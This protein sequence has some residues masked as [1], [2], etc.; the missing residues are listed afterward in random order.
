MLPVRSAANPILSRQDIP[1]VPPELVDVSSVF[2]PGAV[3]R[4]GRCM[5]MLRVQTRGRETFFL[6]AESDDGVRFEVERRVVHIRGMDRVNG[7]VYHCYDARITRLE[8]AYYAMFAMDTDFGCRLGLAR[9]EDF[10]TF[11]FVG[12][13]GGDDT[14]NGVLFPER[15]D[16]C[17]LRLERPNKLR[18]ESGVTSGDEI[19]LST[20]EDLIDWRPAGSVMRG[21]LHYWD[22]LIGPGPPPVKTHEGWLLIYHGIATHGSAGIYQAGVALLDLRNPSNLVARGRNNVLEPRDMYEMTGQVPNVVFPTGLIIERYDAE[23][24]A[25]P[26]GEARIYYGAADTCV[27]LATCTVGDLLAACRD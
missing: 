20:S 4:L 5:L 17:Y 19:M 14:R 7:A 6:M 10:V 11:D 8:D 25:D 12:M 22:E 24:Y 23:G 2:N 16:G 9:T 15:I 18:F 26:A 21:R 27:C 1:D 3:M 13:S